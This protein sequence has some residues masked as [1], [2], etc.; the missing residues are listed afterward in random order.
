MTLE[1]KDDLLVLDEE[2][3]VAGD[4]N[5]VEWLQEQ[6]AVLSEANEQLR[7]DLEAA[8]IGAPAPGAGGNEG[9][10]KQSVVALFNELQ[11]NHLKLGTNPQT[12]VGNFRIYCPGF[13]NRMM[14]F[15]PFLREHKKYQ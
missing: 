13:L 12:G 15:F 14:V 10:L 3:P 11:E 1:K 7:S 4:S 5:D 2:T 9:A 8:S 6:V